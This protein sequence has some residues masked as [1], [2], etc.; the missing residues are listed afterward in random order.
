MGNR[1][2]QSMSQTRL[3]EE[4]EQELSKL[5]EN[6]VELDRQEREKI[7]EN[8]MQ[9][10]EKRLAEFQTVPAVNRELSW[11]WVQAASGALP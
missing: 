4:L 2:D 8:H 7:I 9:P 10:L 3:I 5:D 6:S 11:G 1:S